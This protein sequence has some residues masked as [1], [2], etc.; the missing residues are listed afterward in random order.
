MSFEAQSRLEILEKES[1]QFYQNWHKVRREKEALEVK[2]DEISGQYQ[3]LKTAV[4]IILTWVEAEK[5][6][7][8]TRDKS[9]ISTL[10]RNT[11][12]L[13]KKT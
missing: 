8:S 11:L 1:A 7:L 6:V 9:D 2:I 4:K 5:G 3:D 13:G 10:L 12:K